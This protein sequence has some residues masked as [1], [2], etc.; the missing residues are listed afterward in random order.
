MIKKL[1]I[2]FIVTIFLVAL[3]IHNVS[4]K[5]KDTKDLLI[6]AK[7]EVE[8]SEDIQKIKPIINKQLPSR[9]KLASLRK[10]PNK[11]NIQF[12]DIEGKGEIKAAVPYE[13]ETDKN[14]L[15]VLFLSKISGNWKE[16]DEIKSVGQKFDK[17]VYKDLTGDGKLEVIV[18][19]KVGENSN[20]GISIYK[21][22]NKKFEEIFR[23]YYTDFIV[24]DLDGD[25]M[26]ELVLIK[27]DK[28]TNGSSAELYK[29][30][31]NKLKHI[32]GVSLESSFEPYS[33]QVGNATDKQMG[34]FIDNG[35]GAHSG[36]TELLV[37]KDGKLKNVFYDEKING[38]DKTTKPYLEKSRD[39]DKD[40]IIEIPLMRAP[41]DKKDESMIDTPWITTWCKWDGEESLIP[42]SE[43]YYNYNIELGFDFPTYW[44][45]SIT[46][47][48]S[49]F[50]EENRKENW[51]K[52]SYIDKDSGNKQELFSIK[53]YDKKVWDEDKK[54][55]E[56]EYALLGKSDSKVYTVEM[57]DAI[58]GKKAKD[59][60]MKFSMKLSEIK[61][62]FKIVKPYNKK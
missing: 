9:S 55:I 33:I 61:E 47:D 41:I 32:N 12:I 5:Q 22:K 2:V 56:N 58:Q 60:S 14:P 8:Y 4:K 11:D 7:Q 51:I 31:D 62:R 13:V 38:N 1:S 27:M 44:D 46:I 28:V 23:D 17:I 48:T 57:N 18:G 6:G 26:D 39:K 52:F 37:M 42:I 43:S 25:K 16:D 24:T 34:I 29:W 40:G 21:L 36:I 30:K 19:L 10:G 15:R 54:Y 53:V 59:I 50:Y 45:D 49:K 35:V 3:S 20:K